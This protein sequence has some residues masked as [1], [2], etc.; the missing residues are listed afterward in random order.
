M[1]AKYPVWLERWWAQEAARIFRSPAD[2]LP[3]TRIE[4]A[5]AELGD[6]FTTDRSAG[7]GGYA[8]K[9]ELLAAYALVH[10]PRTFLAVRHVLAELARVRDW[11]P[12]GRLAVADLGCGLGAAAA[13]VACHAQ[14]EP[15][16][17]EVALADVTRLL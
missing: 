14:E 6:L 4:K 16:V 13:A 11:R 1:T 7:F 9:P 12:A 17:T 5:A 2:A 10:F 8:G 15:G 3:M